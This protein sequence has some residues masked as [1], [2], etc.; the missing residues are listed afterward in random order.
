MKMSRGLMT[1]IGFGAGAASILGGV[2]GAAFAGPAANAP[3]AA[4][5][6]APGPGENLRNVRYCEVLT[7]ARQWVTFLVNVYNTTGLN[8]CPADQ[9]Q[10]LDANALAKQLGV[11]AVKLN[12]PRYWTL[13][14]IEAKGSTASGQKAEFGGIA[15]TLRATLQIKLWQG[16][17]GDTFYKANQVRRTT[18]FHYRAGAAVYE[19]ISPSG[20]VYM[21]QSYAQIADPN[22]SLDD[23]SRLGERLKLPAGWKYQTRKLDSDYALI[24]EGVAYVVQDDLY[25]SYQRRPN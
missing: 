1:W 3:A 7:I 10:A 20:D 12:G 5:A 2:C 25:N 17:V 22:L 15:M 21:M 18:V 14:R 9:W 4:Q 11:T 13:D 24:A 6:A 8:L 16:T 23:L 19:L